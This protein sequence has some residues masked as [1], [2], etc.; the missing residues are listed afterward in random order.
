VSAFIFFFDRE[1]Q[2]A[3]G[4]STARQA[5]LAVTCGVATSAV[6]TFVF[7]HLFYVRLP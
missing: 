4:R 3:I 6:V 2:T 1:R 7:Q 5:L